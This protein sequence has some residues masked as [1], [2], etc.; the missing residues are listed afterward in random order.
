MTFRGS[1]LGRIRGTPV[2]RAFGHRN[3][4]LWF[5]GQ[6]IS[7]IGTWMQMVAQSWLVL[8]LTGDPLMMGIVAAAQYSPVLVFG[9][10]GG[11][12]ADGLPKRRVLL[13][14]QTTFGLLAIVLWALSA[15]EIVQVWH[16]ILVAFSFGLTN[17]IDMP[18]RNSF[19][20]EMVGREDVANAVALNS[21]LFNAARIV[22]PAVAGLTIG[23]FGVSVAFLLNGLSYVAVVTGLF[24][25]REAEL[26]SPPLIARPAGARAIFASLAEGLRYVRGTPIVLLCVVLVGTVSTFGMNWTVVIPALARYVLGTDATGYGFLMSASGLGALIAA[27]WIASQRRSRTALI[28]VGALILGSMEVVLGISRIFPLSLAAMLVVGFGSVSMTATANATVQL[29]VPDQLRGRVMSVYMTIFVGSTPIGSLIVG[30]IASAAG[31]DVAVAL[32]GVVSTLAAVGAVVWLR[33]IARAERAE[34]IL[35]TE[36]ASVGRESDPIEGAAPA[37]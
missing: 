34:R 31:T 20:V 9:L 21:A 6:S 15:A 35:A 23:V 36:A 25:M 29:H 10:F 27:L 14:T 7:G 11:L 16:V 17:A 2:W 30:A 24:L 37:A 1:A 22:G 12:V 28:G 19:S 4:R 3:Y 33:R 26:I 8:T 5:T 32:G 18:T 13:A